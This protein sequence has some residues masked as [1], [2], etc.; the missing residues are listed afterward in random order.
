MKS[1][2][3]AI[4]KNQSFMHVRSLW[5]NISLWKISEN[6]TC[7]QIIVTVEATLSKVHYKEPVTLSIYILIQLPGQIELFFM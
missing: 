2:G 7:A 1:H 4:F 5:G 6:Y 3:T